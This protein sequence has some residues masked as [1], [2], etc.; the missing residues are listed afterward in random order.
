VDWETAS[1]QKHD[2]FYDYSRVNYIDAKT[3][4]EI[5]CKK[6]DVWFNQTP[7]KH[8]S[9]KFSCPEC[10]S[11]RHK[12]S[13]D[14][15]RLTF[16][17]FKRRTEIACG[18][19]IL[20]FSQAVYVN[21]QTKVKLRH[22]PCDYWFENRPQK[23]MIG[24]LGCPKC[25]YRRAGDTN[26]KKKT[27]EQW[28]AEAHETHG[29]LYIY[30]SE[31]TNNKGMMDIECTICDTKFSQEA[32][33]HATY[34]QGCPK[35]RYVKSAAG[36][37]LDFDEVLERLETRRQETGKH[38]KYPNLTAETYKRTIDKCEIVC[39]DCDRTFS[40]TLAKHIDRQQGC[41]AC[42]T[43]G[44][45]TG[46]PGYCYLLEYQFSD[47]TIR[48]KQGIAG[49]V[50]S[51]VSQLRRNVNDVFP[52][53]KVTLIDQKYFEVGQ[54]ARDLETYFLSLTDIRWRPDKKFDG[55]TEMYAEGILEAWAERL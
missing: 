47:G 2:D 29:D 39:P 26:F 38:Y 15:R 3:K 24:Q 19:G 45:Q 54:D 31:Y 16:D 28:I 43:T 20:D 41:S 8:R 1:R 22:I 17:D 49:D 9:Q 36:I 48:Y 13:V 40:Q 6:H 51:R 14:K 50:K 30:H 5:R 55:S 23:L 35:C 11:Q 33:S 44:F 21:T 34:G 12:A 18:E 52:E 10:Q 32:K 53:T 46:E 25:R 27:T 37:R 7:D 42:A 4:I